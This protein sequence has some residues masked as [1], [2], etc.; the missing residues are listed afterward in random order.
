MDVTLETEQRLIEEQLQLE[1]DMM[2]GGI[3]RFRKI[4]ELAVERGKESHTPHGRAIIS[5]L[6]HA[7]AGS[8]VQFINNPTNTS[9]DIAWKNLKD[10]DAEQVAYL[11]LVTLV[12]SISRKNT[13]LYVA[14]TIGSN[15]ELS[16][17][18]I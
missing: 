13:L 12:D 3:H 2:T 10:M 18:H 16:L 8:V 17:I 5:R 9:R 1:T 11:S 4:V 15:I 14:R 7:V 6:V